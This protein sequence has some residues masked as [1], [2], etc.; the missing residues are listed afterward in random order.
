MDMEQL[1]VEQRWKAYMDAYA[2]DDEVRRRYLLEQCVTE[3][4]VFT[5]PSGD[6]KSR[7]GLFAHIAKFQATMPGAYFETDKLYP[8]ADKLLAVWSMYKKDGTKVA[9]GYNFVQP[10][11]TGLFRYLAGFF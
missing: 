8:Q 7:T 4:V 11:S 2:A 9:T 1:T 6:G 10:D 3:D 5:N